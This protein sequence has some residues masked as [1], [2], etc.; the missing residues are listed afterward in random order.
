MKGMLYSSLL[1]N[2]GFIKGAGIYTAAAAVA[3]VVLIFISDMFFPGYSP[4][5]AMLLSIMPLISIGIAVEGIGREMESSL[6]SR[7]TNYALSAVSPRKFAV[8]ELLKNLILTAY[9]TTLSMLMAGI[10]HALGAN[11]FRTL[12]DNDIINYYFAVIPLVG[13]AFS[14]LEFGIIPL[15]IKF[16]SAEKAGLVVGII[17]GFGLIFPISMFMDFPLSIHDFLSYIQFPILAY[18]IVLFILLYALFYLLLEKRLERGN[19]C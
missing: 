2:R 17:I 7:F 6:K 12:G 9:G 11:L 5:I 14:L 18:M 1:Y 10:F 13:I 4:A 8:T 16:K 15:V 3:G 19:L